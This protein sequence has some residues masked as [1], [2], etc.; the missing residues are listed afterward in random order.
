MNSISFKVFYDSDAEYVIARVNTALN[1]ADIPLKFSMIPE[2]GGDSF[3]VY[4]L[5]TL[6]TP[7]TVFK[8]AS[9][10]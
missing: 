9:P 6:D 3:V 7:N 2:E 1:A 8:N 4:K 5:V 10:Q